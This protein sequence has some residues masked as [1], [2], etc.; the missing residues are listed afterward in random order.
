[1][2]KHIYSTI[3]KENP[4]GFIFK[5]ESVRKESQRFLFCNIYKQ[6]TFAFAWLLICIKKDSTA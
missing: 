4:A 6:I 1:M 2:A 5:H 3:I